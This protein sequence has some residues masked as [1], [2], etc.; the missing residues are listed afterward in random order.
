[1]ARKL[2]SV[3]VLSLLLGGCSLF[4]AEEEAPVVE[5]PL[6]VVELPPEEPALEVPSRRPGDIEERFAALQADP[7]PDANLLVGMTPEEMRKL[8]GR[9]TQLVANPPAEIWTYDASDC[10]LSVFFYPQVGANSYRALVYE[11]ENG[12]AEQTNL[13]KRERENRCLN[14]LLVE[15]TITGKVA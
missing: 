1:M 15:R 7:P 13:S 11:V 4:V 14:E 2:V 3:A 8:L 12:A 10:R 5:A 6:P 9:P